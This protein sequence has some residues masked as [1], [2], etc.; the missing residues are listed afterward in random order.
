MTNKKR[1][2]NSCIYNNMLIVIDFVEKMGSLRLKQVA[3]SH[4]LL[5]LKFIW[6]QLE[7]VVSNLLKFCLIDQGFMIKRE[8]ITT[9]K[10]NIFKI[11]LYLDQMSSDLQ[12]LGILHSLEKL[13]QVVFGDLAFPKSVYCAY[14]TECLVLFSVPNTLG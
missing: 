10:L 4:L 1:I 8:Q 9:W 11:S 14:D 6:D 12:C 7:N 5:C 2:K 3:A 13:F